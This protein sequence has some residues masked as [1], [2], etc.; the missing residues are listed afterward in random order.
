[1]AQPEITEL[2][3]QALISIFHF[4]IYS[5]NDADEYLSLL[6]KRTEM[7]R[8]RRDKPTRQQISARR[9]GTLRLVCR[10]FRDVIDS[11]TFWAGKTLSISAEQ[12]KCPR[13]PFIAKIGIR[14]IFLALFFEQDKVW[15]PQL[16]ELRS[17]RNLRYISYSSYLDESFGLLQSLSAIPLESVE[18]TNFRYV[19]GGLPLL[20]SVVSK[21]S[22][23]LRVLTIQ[24]DR[25]FKVA[26]FGHYSRHMEPFGWLGHREKVEETEVCM[27]LQREN[28]TLFTRK[29]N[30]MVPNAEFPTL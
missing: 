29:S 8:P 28:K 6:S 21:F 4:V 23:S 2:P 11:P 20:L 15:R 5:V 18:I 17:I 13:W 30:G 25:Q 14:S 26:S 16:R 22:R 10:C 1:M 12:L 27:T 7:N 24:A 19:K 9:L 3:F